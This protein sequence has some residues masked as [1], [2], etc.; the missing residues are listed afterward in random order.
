MTLK[1]QQWPQTATVIVAAQCQ[2]RKILLVNF[3]IRLD[4]WSETK[5]T[6]LL[7]VIL[8]LAFTLLYT[9]L[10]T[11]AWKHI[12][13]TS[14]MWSRAFARS[15]FSLLIITVTIQCHA[16]SW[17]NPYW[18]YTPRSPLH[19]LYP[20]YVHQAPRPTNGHQGAGTPVTKPP[21]KQQG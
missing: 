3:V 15:H 8:L 1:W 20:Q 13:A 21:M 2:D 9:F 11:P 14:K 16:K 6:L 7:H 19:F 10:T 4:H 12:V 17:I 18:S 5:L